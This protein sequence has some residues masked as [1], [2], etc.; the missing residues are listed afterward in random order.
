MLNKIGLFALV[1][2]FF[3]N[4]LFSETATVPRKMAMFIVYKGNLTDDEKI[5][6]SESLLVKIS[7][8][9]S[10]T[11]IEP[12][13]K[14]TKDI[15]YSEKKTRAE[16]LGADA[17]LTITITGE[18][19]RI[20]IIFLAFDI[21][22][23][24]IAIDEKTIE[25]SRE[26]RGL[27]RSFW[28]PVTADVA[29]G[30]RPIS[31]DLVIKEITKHTGKENLIQEVQGVKIVIVAQP[32]TIVAGMGKNTYTADEDGLVRLELPGSSTYELYATCA[33]FYPVRKQIYI[34]NEPLRIELDQE[35]GSNFGVDLFLQQVDY[36]GAGFRWY[37]VPNM[38]FF[39]FRSTLFFWKLI[40]PT[41]GDKNR[42]EAPVTHLGLYGG[43]YINNEDSLFRFSVSTGVFCRLTFIEPLGII[44]DPISQF[45]IT[46]GALDIEISP[47]EHYRFF[48]EYS[49]TLYFSNN[50]E[51]FKAS[52]T[53]NKS[54]NN[55][56]TPGYAFAGDI[57]FDYLDIKVGFRIQL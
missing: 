48:I 43:F 54:N 51:L 55:G 34:A 40:W 33:G 47:M 49:P 31:G 21:L 10:I 9:E 26:I 39:D 23:N 57:A 52:V 22:Q 25:K 29:N 35:Q 1:V 8:I 5:V 7:E 17:Y 45:G 16:G 15:T 42:Y 46:F 38:W 44:L 4:L 2:L 36:I 53:S 30:F 20:Q 50:I 41:N 28:Q 27:D 3:S 19:D 11:V 18:K 32:K 12:M 56:K 6:L 24:K 13:W 37:Y 14:G